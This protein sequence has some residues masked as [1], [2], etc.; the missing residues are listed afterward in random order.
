MVVLFHRQAHLTHD[1]EH[2]AAHVLGRVHRVHREVATLG[3]HAVAHVTV[4][5]VA[6]RVLRQFNKIVLQILKLPAI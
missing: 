6:V 2:F 1:A 3:A 4:F 5:V